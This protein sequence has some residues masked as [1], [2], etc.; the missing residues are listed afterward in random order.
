MLTGTD[1]ITLIGLSFVVITLGIGRTQ[2]GWAWLLT[3]YVTPTLVH[4]SGVFLIAPRSYAAVWAS[5]YLRR[6]LW[7]HDRLRIARNEGLLLDALSFHGVWGII[8]AI[9][10]AWTEVG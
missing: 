1:A 10:G 6:C 3:T 8:A 5:R 9:A 2:H 4:F 7:F